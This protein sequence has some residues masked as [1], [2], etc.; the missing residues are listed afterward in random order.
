[1]VLNVK[2][3]KAGDSSHLDKV[4]PVILDAKNKKNLNYFDEDLC[5][6]KFGLGQLKVRTTQVERDFTSWEIVPLDFEVGLHSKAT[7]FKQYTTAEQHNIIDEG[8]ISQLPDEILSRILAY[9]P[10]KETCRTSIL[11]KRWKRV[12]TWVADLDFNGFTTLCQRRVTGEVEGSL[13]HLP[14]LKELSIE[15]CLAGNESMCGLTTFF[16]A[17]PNLEKFVIKTLYPQKIITR[18]GSDN[19]VDC[20][21]QHLRVVEISQYRGRSI[22]FELVQYLLKNAISLEKIIVDP[23]FKMASFGGNDWLLLESGTVDGRDAL[24]ERSSRLNEQIRLG[25]RPPF[26][27]EDWFCDLDTFNQEARITEEARRCAEQQL[28]GIIMPPHV[29]L[30]IL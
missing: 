1:M 23:R 6:E 25:I 26:G 2:E 29:T 12:W 9:L 7:H 3:D 10:L 21:L 15:L 14:A 17:S 8:Q 27:G 19:V 24:L 5:T 22:E 16:R 30:Q 20:P 11:S 28:L 4:N 13:P 18:R